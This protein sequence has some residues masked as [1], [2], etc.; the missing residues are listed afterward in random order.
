MNTIGIVALIMPGV[1]I[2]TR[3]DAYTQAGPLVAKPW[4]S[5][6][7]PTGSAWTSLRG[8]HPGPYT[9]PGSSGPSDKPTAAP[10]MIRDKSPGA[11]CVR[12]SP[13]ASGRR[14]VRRRR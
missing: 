10:R 5:S 2:F 12:Y 13:A 4:A 14:Y 1:A 6:C 7:Q 8:S 11:P 3:R 9:E